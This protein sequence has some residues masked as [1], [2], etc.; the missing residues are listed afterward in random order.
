[1]SF[2]KHVQPRYN[3]VFLQALNTSKKTPSYNPI[4]LSLVSYS[5][6]PLKIQLIYVGHMDETIS[7]LR[8]P[9]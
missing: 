9:C 6:E 4:Y 7:I 8:E 2:L 5:V 3:V 1:M